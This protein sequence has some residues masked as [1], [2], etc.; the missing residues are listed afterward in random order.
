MDIG[1]EP[2]AALE[3]VRLTDLDATT[4]SMNE[5]HASQLG[6]FPTQRADSYPQD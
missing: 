6:H 1:F 3:G 5:F 4:S 2:E